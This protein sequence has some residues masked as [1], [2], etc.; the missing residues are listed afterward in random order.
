MASEGSVSTSSTRNFENDN[1]RYLTPPPPLHPPY[2]FT[3]IED[4]LNRYEA[5]IK[6]EKHLIYELARDVKN[7][8]FKVSTGFSAARNFIPVVKITNTSIL[9]NNCITFDEKDWDSCTY[10]LT[11]S[12]MKYFE[13]QMS[14]VSAVKFGEYGMEFGMFMGRK[15]IMLKNSNFCTSLVFME[16]AVREIINLVSLINHRL[17]LLKDMNFIACYNEVLYTVKSLCTD[18]CY[19]M[20][21]VL[22][23]INLMCDNEFTNPNFYC[24]RE[25]VLYA[26]EQVYEDFI[27]L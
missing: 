16:D 9:N 3:Y 18:M 8:S 2:P 22:G 21:N 7:T 19:N 20:R 17:S 25:S 15:T 6:G 5:K 27:R 10:F 12:I 24:L 4:V 11:S 26:P 23:E 13:N 1:L 14:P